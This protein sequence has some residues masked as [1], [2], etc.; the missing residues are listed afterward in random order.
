MWKETSWI[1]GSGAFCSLASCEYAAGP[2]ADAYDPRSNRWFAVPD[3]AMTRARLAAATGPDGRIYAI[4]GLDIGG[5]PLTSVEA[6]DP[7][8]RHW[9]TVASLHTPR[10]GVAAAT[11]PDGRIYALGGFDLPL[12][13]PL[14]RPVT[15][16][17]TSVEAYGPLIHL[18]P[19]SS[20]R[21]GTVVLTG[22]NFAALAT[23]SVTWGGTPRGVVLTTGQTD[24][25][26]ALLQSLRFPIPAGT[27][28]GQ[29]G[30]TARDN[31]SRY[32]VTAP[33][34]VAP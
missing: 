5:E 18:T 27:R 25:A 7:R 22:T 23:V 30:V 31:R 28:P 20:A 32:P 2:T 3:M 29:Y 26:G 11:G 14:Y 8:T 16:Y 13:D 9:S 6:Y 12:K 33:L 4:G 10:F 19:S 1:K 21:G 17:L 34:T 15:H 24:R